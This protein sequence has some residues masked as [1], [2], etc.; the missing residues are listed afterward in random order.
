MNKLFFLLITLALFLGLMFATDYIS[1]TYLLSDNYVPKN[2]YNEEEMQEYMKDAM[3]L[4]EFREKSAAGEEIDIQSPE[5]MPIEI[6]MAQFYS[7]FLRIA[8]FVVTLILSFFAAFIIKD[9]QVDFSV[10]ALNSDERGINMARIALYVSVIMAT[11]VSAQKYPFTY[12][13]GWVSTVLWA[14]TFLVIMIWILNIIYAFKKRR[15][16]GGRALKPLR[17]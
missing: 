16:M 13:L 6:Q 15:Q 17:K 12:L 9:S 5:E 3:P 7:Y 1:V 11:Y 8:I 14:L 4:E 10:M 2:N